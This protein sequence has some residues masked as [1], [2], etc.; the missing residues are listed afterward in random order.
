MRHNFTAD[1]VNREGQ[2]VRVRAGDKEV[3][4]V[5]I[6]KGNTFTWDYT[7]D[8]PTPVTFQALQAIIG[9]AGPYWLTL[10]QGATLDV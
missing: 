2:P 7:L 9:A 8:K 1:P 3:G 5:T 6:R 4:R 10:N